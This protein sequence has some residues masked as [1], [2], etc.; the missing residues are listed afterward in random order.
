MNGRT[1]AQAVSCR[2]PTAADRVRA[3]VRSCG[4]CS[5][6]SGTGAGFLRIL[7]FPLP[8]LIPSIAPLSPSSIIRGWY[9]R[10]NSGRRTKCTKSVTH[11]VTNFSVL[12]ETRNIITVFTKYFK[13][14]IRP[15]CCWYPSYT[16]LDPR[17]TRIDRNGQIVVPRERKSSPWHSVK[18]PQNLQDLRLSQRRS[19]R[20]ITFLGRRAVY[21]KE[22]V[23]SMLRVQR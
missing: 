4:I 16:S 6:Q 3:R 13:L 19:W 12:C 5:G 22:H 9:S 10:P 21:W 15:R 17:L 1:I 8:I 11:Q 7:R 23:A 2:L 14:L 20:E 18:L